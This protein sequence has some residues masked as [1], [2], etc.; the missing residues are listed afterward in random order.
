MSK[1]RAATQDFSWL[2]KY[3][4]ASAGVDENA[5][6]ALADPVSSNCKLETELD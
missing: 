3:N 5:E 4:P 6:D 2:D 1:K